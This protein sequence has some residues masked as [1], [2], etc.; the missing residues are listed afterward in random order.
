MTRQFHQK[1]SNVLL[2]IPNLSRAGRI[3]KIVVFH[4]FSHVSRSLFYSYSLRCERAQ[5][6][7]I[8][9]A[10]RTDIDPHFKLPTAICATSM[11]SYYLHDF[12]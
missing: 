12:S 1:M 3:T 7:L 5:V 11:H 4:S 2:E 10:A 6:E 9:T 8:I